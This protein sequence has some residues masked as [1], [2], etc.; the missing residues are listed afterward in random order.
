[1]ELETSGV[2]MSKTGS[3]GRSS[4]RQERERGWV[5]IDYMY[6]EVRVGLTSNG[7]WCGNEKRKTVTG[8]GGLV[9]DSHLAGSLAKP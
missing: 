3:K 5:A 4:E 9:D 8:E 7:K 1:M 6:D 2:Y